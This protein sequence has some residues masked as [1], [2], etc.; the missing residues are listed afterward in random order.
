MEWLIGIYLVIGLFKGIGRIADG[1][2]LN[3]PG[4]MSSERNPLAYSFYFCMY[5]LFWPLIRG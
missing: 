2:P 4:W 5:V 1:N 3:K